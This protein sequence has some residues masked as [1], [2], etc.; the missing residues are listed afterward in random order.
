MTEAAWT[1]TPAPTYPAYLNAQPHPDGNAMILTARSAPTR[2]PATPATGYHPGS[3][4]RV[5]CGSTVQLLIPLDAW[6]TF[7]AAVIR[8]RQTAD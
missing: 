5:A 6:D 3:E 1:D 4:E 8:V 2:F 7:I